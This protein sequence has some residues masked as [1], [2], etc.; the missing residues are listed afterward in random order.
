MQQD[1]RTFMKSLAA[2]SAVIAA[3][4]TPAMLSEMPTGSLLG[5]QR[6]EFMRLLGLWRDSVQAMLKA[7]YRFLE[8]HPRHAVF[9]KDPATRIKY[10]AAHTVGLEDFCSHS[11]FWPAA[12][13]ADFDLK[14]EVFRFVSS[15]NPHI[16]EID[17]KGIIAC[18]EMERA[19]CLG[20]PVP[21]SPA[22]EAF[23]ER[24]LNTRKDYRKI[25]EPSGLF[26]SLRALSEKPM[27]TLEVEQK[28]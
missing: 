19:E 23:L 18:I 12:T 1:R 17:R 10:D 8:Q 14:L 3:P 4:T 6:T 27:A 25:P 7:E 16:D 24:R 13:D 11:A 26:E 21:E 20:R 9:E 5:A 28:T 22:Y 15:L 2:L